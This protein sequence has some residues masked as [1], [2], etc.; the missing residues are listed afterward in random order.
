MLNENND[1]GRIIK[2]YRESKNYSQ[3]KLAKQI[4]V[5]QR[6]VSYYESGDHI[7]PADVLKKLANIFN[8]SIDVLVGTKK[9]G[10]NGNCDN[11]FYEEGLANWEIRKKAKELNLSYEDILDRTGINSE[12]FDLLWFGNVQPYAEELIRFSEVLDVSIDYLLDNSQRER[13]SVDEEIIL[14]YYKKYPDEI[15]DLL[16]SFTSLS[17][18][19]R[20][21]V[22]G[23]CFE[24][25]QEESVTADENELKMAK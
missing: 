21:I 9:V 18:K 4:G 13:V 19:G 11:Y 5:S 8:I 2:Y 20:T 15:M 1:I 12:R 23:K 14:R 10:A 6:N 17:K 24:L 3:S 16:S 7:P 22:S 25:E